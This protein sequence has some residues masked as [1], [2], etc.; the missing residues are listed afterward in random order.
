MFQSPEILG[1]YLGSKGLL[2]VRGSASDSGFTVTDFVHDEILVRHAET[3][4]QQLRGLIESRRLRSSLAAFGLSGPQVLHRLLELPPIPI[5][6]LGPIV[7]REMRAAGAMEAEE[8]VFDWELVERGDKAAAKGVRVLAAIAPRSQVEQILEMAAQCLLRATLVTTVPIALLR[9]LRFLNDG[10][11]GVK[12]VIYMGQREGHLLGVENGSWG[13]HRDF[14]SRVAEGGDSKL[15]DEALREANRAILYS[16]QR[17]GDKAEMGFLVSG[18]TG[19]KEVQQRLQRELGA[20]AEVVRPAG[21]LD[22]TS[23]GGR[24]AAFRD[25]FPQWII[26]LGLAAAATRRGINLL[27]EKTA[28]RPVTWRPSIKLPAMDR[29]LLPIVVLGALL[30]AHFLLVR[31]E[32]YYRRLLGERVALYAQWLPVTRAAEES[33][34]LRENERLFAQHLDRDHFGDTRW[35]LLFK[36]LSRIAPSELTLQSMTLQRESE[37]WL[38]TIKGEVVS[39]DPYAGQ[40][41]FNRFYQGLKVSS[42]FE[43]VDLGPPVVSTVSQRIEGAA[44]TGP[45]GDADEK[46]A[47]SRE[48]KKTKIAFE[49]RAYT[50]EVVHGQSRI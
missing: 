44:K 33:R 25:D 1:V 20:R 12:A 21:N 27:P 39:L 6:E 17:Y 5:K 19:V 41:A 31:S 36:V 46:A 43:R 45:S 23:L 26:P 18:E 37:K 15:D 4:T 2:V 34:E 16:R 47:D 29:P 3:V 38:V 32:R 11:N 40:T 35:A 48:V 14:S 24:A 22:L 30:V 42:Y 13:F 7:A 49:I 9:S 28:R 10:A 8:V 50:A